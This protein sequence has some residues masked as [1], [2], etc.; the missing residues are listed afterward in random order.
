MTTFNTDNY[1]VDLYIDNYPG[2]Y[3]TFSFYGGGNSSYYSCSDIYNHIN[4]TDTNEHKN[5]IWYKV[6]NE[7]YYNAPRKLDSKPA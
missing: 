7:I 4:N 3:K 5:Y 1:I 6:K 2:V